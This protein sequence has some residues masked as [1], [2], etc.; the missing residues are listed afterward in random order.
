MTRIT[1][2]LCAAACVAGAPCAQ[3]QI[4][5]TTNS[6]PAAV[7]VTSA[8]P[9]ARDAPY[10]GT[11]TLAID[12]TDAATGAFRVT[13]TIPV[14]PGA[15]QIT[16]LLPEWIPGHHNPTGTPAELAG[17]HFTAAGQDLAW[18]R[19]PIDVFAYIVDLPA[20]TREVVAR[21]IHTSP[22]RAEPNDRVTVTR[23]IINLQWDK[24]TLYPAGHYARQIRV[25][26]TVTFPA[27]F[28]AYSALDGQVVAGARYGW[29]TTDYE[30]LVDSPIFAGKYARRI[31]L[32]DTVFLNAVADKPDQLAISDENLTTYRNLVKEADATFGARHFDHYDVLLG[33]TDRLTDIGLEHHRS[34]ES[35]YRPKAWT[36]WAAFDWD[37]NVVAHEYVHSW[38]GKFRRPAR[39]WTPDY[40]QPMV[41]DLL[42]VYE[43]QT[44]FWGLVLAARS[45]VQSRAMVLAQIATYAGGFTTLAGR[46]WRAVSDTTAD[47]IFAARRPKPFASLS[48]GEDYYTEGALV[49]L[50]ADQ[51]IRDG[52]AG[53]KGL[54]DFARGFF[55]MRPGDWGVLPYTRA[56]VVAALNAIHAYDWDGF[57]KTRIET[58]G[59]PVPLG[60]IE[61]GGY[62]LVWKDEP[63]VYDAGRMADSKA[64]AL[65]YSLGLS[66]DRD[67]KVLATAWGSPAFKAGI[68]PG[69]QIFAVN[70]DAYDG[71]TIRAAISAATHSDAPIALLVK[72]DGRFDTV[73][74]IWHGGLRY[75]WLER[76][77][78]G[79]APGGIDRLLAPR[80]A[81]SGG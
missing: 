43:G 64:L 58:P 47:P 53:K 28:T 67:G 4:Q 22:L 17:I 70:G 13:E 39:L 6:F 36:D 72:R 76:N 10:P 27:G 2:L 20:A 74:V 78:G 19:D 50:E 42:W 8:L 31:A 61:R 37:R 23:E 51:I 62:R 68:V 1:L 59:Q 44:Q 16:L 24:M 32:D 48:R 3:A 18:H 29:D 54:D 35:T 15:R 5:P 7:P 81:P 75:P 60:G 69:V 57:F 26:P 25:R 34:N 49:W 14:E 55:G 33:L 38:N 9:E 56:D 77:A 40:R 11:I 12:A 41:T 46:E 71:E 63:N 66:I 30:T 65:T 21:M 73:P 52:T 79:K 80:R 45:G